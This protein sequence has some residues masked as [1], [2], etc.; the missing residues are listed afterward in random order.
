V[1][2][3]P[4]GKIPLPAITPR[5]VVL[6]VVATFVVVLG[7]SRIDAFQQMFFIMRLFIY[8]A[9]PDLAY[10]VS[11]YLSLAEG[12]YGDMVVQLTDSC[13][14]IFAPLFFVLL[15]AAL[16]RWKLKQEKCSTN[17]QRAI[18]E[19]I[20]I[21]ENNFIAL[22]IYVVLNAAFIVC[23][24]FLH[25]Y[26]DILINVLSLT[27]L[28]L[29]HIFL[30]NKFLRAGDKHFALSVIA[31]AIFIALG[32]AVGALA[33][34]ANSWSIESLDALRNTSVFY[35]FI[36]DI[37]FST[38]QGSSLFWKIVIPIGAVVTPSALMML[39]LML[40]RA[41]SIRKLKALRCKLG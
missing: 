12:G 28:A 1:L 21:L 13:I 22:L 6:A 18:I 24:E 9:H 14:A 38:W 11:N 36:F 25:L 34:Y 35:F 29:L 10:T 8:P 7:A 32:L 30:A 33:A 15:G 39:G 5:F 3:L 20:P 19:A 16:Q 27:A 23:V 40:E 37:S 17:Q 31:P 2:R 41:E 26:Q 4:D